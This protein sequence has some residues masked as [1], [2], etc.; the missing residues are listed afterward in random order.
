MLAR[1]VLRRTRDLSLAEVFRLE[2][3]LSVGCCTQHD[4][5]E[6]VRA[7]LIDKDRTPKWQPAT[8]QGVTPTLIAEHFKPRYAGAHPLA[9]LG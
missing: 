1:E 8:L 4:F 5:A 9:D 2:Y 6:G 7:L 3:Q